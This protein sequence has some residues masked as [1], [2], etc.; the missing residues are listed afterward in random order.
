MVS[1]PS[2]ARKSQPERSDP[3]SG[4]LAWSKD[5]ATSV[6]AVLP[7]WL[8]YEA[9][10]LALAP[11]ERN[12]AEAMLTETLVTF[13]PYAMIVLR[14]LLAVTVLFAAVSI[15]ARQLPWARVTLVSAL[16]GTVYGVL[17][18]PVTSALTLEI[19]TGGALLR[20]SDLAPDLVGSLSAGIFEEAVFRLGLLS[21]L[22]LLLGRAFR[23]F[24]LP[25]ELGIAIAIVISAVV[26]SGFHHLGAGAEPFRL[27]VFV[28][29]AVAGLL[30][31]LLFV[32]RGFGV[33]V[34]THALYDVH[35]YLTQMD[36]G[37]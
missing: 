1:H 30:L 17:L 11:D 14:V 2:T 18:G 13:G 34:Y 32:F 27:E 21:L 31:G 20:V 12:G 19:L 9:L 3:P 8:L 4:Y 6:F 15:H 29:R 37:S 28:F 33:C 5:P 26:F 16:E 36:G 23:G 35:F 10:R 22:A 24:S 7:L 25:G